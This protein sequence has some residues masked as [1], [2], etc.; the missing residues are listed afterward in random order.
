MY[1]VCF[2]FY[3][4]CLLAFITE[5]KA[6]SPQKKLD[7]LLS[8]H[9]SYKKE[10][11]TQ[12]KNLKEIYRQYMRLKN[13]NKAEE[14]ARKTINLAT[15]LHIRKFE[16]EAYFRLGTFHHGFTNYEKAEDYYLKAVRVY[17]FL[18]DLDWEAGT[19]LNLGA[20]YIAIPDYAKAL[21][22]N[23]KA[24]NVFQKNG[25]DSNLASCYVNVSEIYEE[26][27][28]QEDALFYLK[29][30]LK[31]F[32]TEGENTRGVAVAC[33]QI[34]SGYFSAS[35]TELI[36][37]GVQ[38]G[39]RNEM[40][41]SYYT[42]ALNAA[43][44]IKDEGV[45]GTIYM[46][47]GKLYEVVGEPGQ[48]LKAYQAAVEKSALEDS[49]LEYSFSLLALA[50][51]YEKSKDYAKSE[52]LLL[53][54]L[55]LGDEHKLIEV[56]RDAYQI[57]SDI[58]EQR[59]NFNQSLG[60]YKKYIIFKEQI[61]D[62]E[63]EKDIT[64]KQL[65][66]K[67]AVKENDYRLKQQV[68]DGELQQQLLLAKQQQQKLV[69]R[70]QALELSDQEKT[71]QRL[72]FLKKEADLENEKRFQQELYKQAQVKAKLD[73]EINEIEIAA[74]KTELNFNKN[75]NIFLG[76]L[77]VI[78]LSFAVVVFYT[79]RKTARLNKIVSEQKVA[80]EKLGK[81]KDRIFSVVGHD[82]RAPVNSLLSF[83]QLLEEGN[84]EQNKL[85]RYAAQLKGSLSH[86]SGM[87]ENLLNWASSQMQGFK[88][89]IEEF[90]MNSCVQ[91]VID[92]VDEAAEK[93]KIV[94]KNNIDGLQQCLADR[95]MTALVFRNLLN[96]AIKF[97]REHGLIV[98]SIERHHDHLIASV[99]DNGVGLSPAQIA[100]FN[101]PSFDEHAQ[102]TTLGTHK[103]KGTGIGLLL[104]KT[105]TQ[106]MNGSLQVKSE[107]EV[108]TTFI[109]TLPV[110]SYPL[111]SKG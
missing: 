81:V 15:K 41:L 30:A 83:I 64:R 50:K 18:K 102:T 46:N 100:N 98:V 54:A 44:A 103:E 35:D 79:Q 4:C 1:K 72:T 71:L 73:K 82:M 2:L 24:I 61:I 21:E 32:E 34:G 91:E 47:L 108:G 52:R 93:K 110:A 111:S 97:T 48:A 106:L 58:E 3:L 68:T 31:I 92:L 36:K 66:M 74:Q 85:S 87:M 28:Q 63:K 26:L 86:T 107:Q 89:I 53:E 33:N 57:L 37:M 7:S 76:L 51:F 105:F 59:N 69:L 96:N 25:D 67:F 16:A 17:A 20:L 6:Q 80:L 19:Y 23:Q 29:K 88:P 22:V 8:I 60:Y 78:L 42:R 109:L 75:I 39:K 56:Q 99:S 49:K 5:L 94:I 40:A 27:D 14:Y 43:V 38:P 70:Q 62:Q 84:I 55:K 101:Y 13:V 12:V 104:C 65:Q 11:S 9:A 45:Q 77:A 95:N 90:D 10:D